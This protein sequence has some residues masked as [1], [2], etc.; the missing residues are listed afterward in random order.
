MEGH[1]AAMKKGEAGNRYLL[2]GENASFKHVFD[3]AAAIT[4]TKKPLFSIPLWLIQL[5]G[6]LSVFFS[7]ITGMLPLISPPVSSLSLILPLFNSTA[8]NIS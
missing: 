5:Y 8:H 2:T 3:M 1:I 7:R 4:H 6:C